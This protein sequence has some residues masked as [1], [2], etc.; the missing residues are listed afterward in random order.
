MTLVLDQALKI[1]S[2]RSRCLYAREAKTRIQQRDWVAEKF[3]FLLTNHVAEFLLS[4]RVWR[5]NSLD[6]KQA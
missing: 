5:T 1:K 2:V 3:I 6:G 4:L